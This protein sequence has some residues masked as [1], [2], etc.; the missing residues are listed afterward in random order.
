M[1]CMCNFYFISVIS[2][3]I[4]GW[5]E[6]NVFYVSHAQSAMLNVLGQ[7]Q[8][9]YVSQAIHIPSKMIMAVKQ[10][11]I[12]DRSKRHQIM[13]ELSALY[14]VIIFLITILFMYLV[15]IEA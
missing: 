6:S 1:K 13:N 8:S 15:Y 14:K 4:H 9:G 2:E 5:V 11:S 12:Y 10:I 7:G 3:I